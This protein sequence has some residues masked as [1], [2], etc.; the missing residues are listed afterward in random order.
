MHLSKKDQLTR[1]FQLSFH[2]TGDREVSKTISSSI[3]KVIR[4][5]WRAM[6]LKVEEVSKVIMTACKN[7]SIDHA[8]QAAR[9]RQS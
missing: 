5:E 8:K 1:A 7:M 3:T 6:G 2:L 9:Q 4:R